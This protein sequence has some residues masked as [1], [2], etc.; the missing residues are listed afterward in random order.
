MDSLL[1]FTITKCLACIVATNTTDVRP[2]LSNNNNTIV[3]VVIVYH[4]TG[5]IIRL[6]VRQQH[7]SAAPVMGLWLHSM[8][9]Q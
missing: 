5:V 2:P 9:S 8:T 6:A 3:V 1:V 7:F 4:C